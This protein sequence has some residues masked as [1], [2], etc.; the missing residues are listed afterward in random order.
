MANSAEAT[1]YGEP[2]NLTWSQQFAAFWSILWPCLLASYFLDAI[3]FQGRPITGAIQFTPIVIRLLGQGILS[4]R[5]VRKNYRTFWIGVLRQGEP[6]KRSFGFSESIRVWIQLI[7][8]Q[9][10]FVVIV[11]LFFAWNNDRASAQTMRSLGSLSN[12][13]YYLVVGPLAIDWAMYAHY[14]GFRLQA[15][16]RKRKIEQ[17]PG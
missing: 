8:L 13:L 17:Q 14:R 2:I 10:A 6:L 1:E 5:L 9:I 11:S 15:Y 3:F 16:R 7:W 4:F 12:F